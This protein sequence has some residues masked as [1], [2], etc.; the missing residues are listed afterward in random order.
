MTFS[1][2]F[3]FQLIRHDDNRRRIRMYIRLTATAATINRWF[4]WLGINWVA[5][6]M[7]LLY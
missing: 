7:I 4:A 3:L 6:M 5:I 1:R 2:R